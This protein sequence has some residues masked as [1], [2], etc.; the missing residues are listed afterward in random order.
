MANTTF[1]TQLGLA[2]LEGEYRGPQQGV[3]TIPWNGPSP[4]VIT[5]V[6][7]KMGGAPNFHPQFRV[8]VILK[9]PAF[10][11]KDEAG[12]VVKVFPSAD[13]AKITGTKP[14]D[15][16]DAKG[17]DLSRNIAD[18]LVSAGLYTIEQINQI[19]AAQKAGTMPL[20][21]PD[22]LIANLTGRP[23]F[24]DVGESWSED[25]KGY[26]NIDN[27]LSKEQHDEAYKTPAL[28]RQDRSA[29]PQ[30]SGRSTSPTTVGAGALGAPVVPQLGGRPAL[31]PIG[32]PMG[33]APAQAPQPFAAV[34]P[35]QAPQPFAQAPQAPQAPQTIPT[36][37]GLPSL[38]GGLPALGMLGLG[39]G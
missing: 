23:C 2:G 25:G 20:W 34:A 13:G 24:V 29:A 6:E 21:T 7:A 22:A 10:A 19:T 8:T 36:N 18:M 31:G 11:V 1:P 27:F 12:N 37:G 26:S 4:A 9:A 15:G 38:G 3:D 5:G 32:A 17:K 28:Y 39:N 35:A 16:K 30:P 33:A 14:I